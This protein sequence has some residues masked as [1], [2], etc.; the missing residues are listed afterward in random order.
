MESETW[1]YTVVKS[2]K[3]ASLFFILICFRLALFEIITLVINHIKV[4]LGVDLGLDILNVFPAR[5]RRI[6][7]F[8]PGKKIWGKKKLKTSK[9]NNNNKNPSAI[10]EMWIEVTC[11]CVLM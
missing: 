3:G 2:V 5:Q 9:N 1:I 7:F 11:V 8:F 6:F 4:K 10:D